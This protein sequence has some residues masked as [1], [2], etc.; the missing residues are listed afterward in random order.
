MRKVALISSIGVCVSIVC[1][2]APA[3]AAVIVAGDPLEG[4]GDVKRKLLTFEELTTG[5][6]PAG[7]IDDSAFGLPKQGAMPRHDFQGALALD[8]PL[9][10][11]S[12][13]ELR[14]DRDETGDADHERKHL[15]AMTIELVQA[16]SHLIPVTQG[17]AYSG[18][19]YWNYIVAVS[20]THLTLPTILRV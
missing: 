2:L 20:Y 1:A 8:Q 16:G 7:P 11:G 18:S 4:S 13:R 17:L 12:F 15:P 6:A 5:A 19:A 3:A 14:D 10:V 9:A